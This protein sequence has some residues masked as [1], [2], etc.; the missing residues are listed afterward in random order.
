MVVSH[1]PLEHVRLGQPADIRLCPS[2]R[3]STADAGHWRLQPPVSRQAVRLDRRAGDRV[4]AEGTQGGRSLVGFQPVR[5]SVSRQHSQPSKRGRGAQLEFTLT[6][7]DWL[8]SGRRGLR[9]ILEWLNNL[10]GSLTSVFPP[11]EVAKEWKEGVELVVRH[12]RKLPKPPKEI[13]HLK[14]A[15]E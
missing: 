8:V 7:F 9:H 13:L 6:I 3:E 11:L 12:Q 5:A 4:E 2:A 15:D 10:L 14:A 1:E